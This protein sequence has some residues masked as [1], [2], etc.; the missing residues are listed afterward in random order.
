[1]LPFG[2]WALMRR[3]LF[4]LLIAPLVVLIVIGGQL[5]ARVSADRDAAEAA[6]VVVK[7]ATEVANVDGALGNETLVAV[8]TRQRPGSDEPLQLEIARA[9]TDKAVKDLEE[10][11]DQSSDADQSLLTAVN[12]VRETLLGRS[13]LAQGWISPLQLV[14]RYGTARHGLVHAM[15][16]RAAAETRNPH[17][18]DLLGLISLVEARSAHL[19]ERVS[20]DLVL[21][22]DDWAPGQHSAAVVAVSSQSALI[23]RASALAGSN[24]L[25]EVGRMAEVRAI[26]LTSDGDVPAL[27]RGA[28]RQLSD[29]WL[30]QLN[31]RVDRTAEKIE[32]RVNADASAAI[33]TQ[34]YTILGVLFA[35][36]MAVCTAALFGMRLV[37]R[38]GRIARAAGDLSLEDAPADS[39]NDGGSD[40][41]AE[42]ADAFDRMSERIRHSAAVRDVESEVRASILSEQPLEQTLAACARLL[43]AGS[44][45][46]IDD[47][48][49][50]LVD[51]TGKRTRLD[52]SIEADTSDDHR[53]AVDLAQVAQLRSQGLRALRH[54]ATFD[55]LTHLLNRSAVL[56]KLA[57]LCATGNPSVLYLD[58][59]H[60]KKLN[61]AHGHESGDRALVGV[62][63]VLE[64]ISA[65]TNGIPGRIGGDEF[66]V[67]VNDELDDEA[68]RAVG[69]A[70]VDQVNVLTGVASTGLTAS[71]GIA[72]N[73]FG[74]SAEELVHEA[75]AAMYRA[76][77]DGRSRVVLADA[78]V[79]SEIEESDKIER[80]LAIALSHD[81]FTIALQG[82][83]DAQGKKLMAFEALAR[84]T[85]A[86]GKS[87]SPAD[88]FA[89]A[90][91]IGRAHEIDRLILRKVCRQIRQWNDAGLTVPPV[92]VNMSAQTLSRPAIVREMLT[93]LRAEG[94]PPTALVAEITESSLISEIEVAGNR[95][96]QLRAEGIKIA[97]DDFGEG[98]SSLRYLSKLPID[99]LKIDRQ[100]ID[101]I[102][103]NQNNRAI[104]RAVLS[105]ANTLGMTVVA[106]GVERREEQELLISFGCSQ[107]QGY[108]FD[109]P[110]TAESVEQSF[111]AAERPAWSNS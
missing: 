35:T 26:V 10:L 76:K 41:I 38:V 5:T 21:R 23:D 61:D 4:A 93:M 31:E 66:I 57:E 34:R 56:R 52:R 6:E 82:I 104:V 85:D 36:A 80:G 59:D 111:L 17:S 12:D 8:T 3:R 100:F 83:W 60:F 84:W 33:T 40:E 81:E 71:V 89:V 101:R 7:I 73:R 19:D 42:M 55:A 43:P 46:D 94:C 27:T 91:R 72:P 51:P 16:T 92:H 49:V 99:I 45:F 18:N 25:R 30:A 75:D 37:R 68:L 44:R 97:V 2:R 48:I 22:Y 29:N 70:I 58:L 32:Q 13:D 109:R 69:N 1:M 110:S 24:P 15:V 74:Q 96:D 107:L 103:S 64:S 105:L 14:D 98:Y 39:L 102:D 95:L 65:E 9:K 28:W 86:N 62:A 90:E 63:R 50:Y 54:Q 78:S 88:F 106:E 87:H 77:N 11:L 79:R 20:V 53:L 108:L 67:I 47:T